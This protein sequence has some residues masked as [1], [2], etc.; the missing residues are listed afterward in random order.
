MNFKQD[1][2]SVEWI[3]LAH[4]VVQWQ[5]VVKTAKKITLLLII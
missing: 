5:A 3:L 1:V 2:K 4:G